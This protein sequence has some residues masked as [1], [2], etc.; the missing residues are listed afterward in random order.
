[1][2]NERVE[3]ILLAVQSEVDT[4][5]DLLNLLTDLKKKGYDL[6]TIDL[7]NGHSASMHASLLERELTD[8]SIVR[9]LILG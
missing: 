6:S 2:R 9:T 4:A 1:M 8:Y 3:P 7:D 5:E